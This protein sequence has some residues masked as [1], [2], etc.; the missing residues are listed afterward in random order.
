VKSGRQDSPWFTDE[1]WM[2]KKTALKQL[3]KLAP[4]SVEIQRAAVLDDVAEVGL[5]QDLA[6]LAD[7]TA[8][9][10]ALLEGDT[11]DPRETDLEMPTRTID[12]PPAA[13]I[14]TTTTTTTLAIVDRILETGQGTNA[15]S[16]TTQ[17]GLKL[18][19]RDAGLGQ[20]L[21]AAK[22]ALRQFTAEPADAQ[23]RRKLIAI[24]E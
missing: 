1:A 8:E 21:I 15:W 9:A 4:M 6:V 16:A 7:P 24:A 18:W 14:P 12:P 3:L 2:W 13:A 23:G 10:T 22:G 17:G 20:Q 11:D 5:P 19:T